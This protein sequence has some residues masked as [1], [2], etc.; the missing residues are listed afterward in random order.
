MF[1]RK[2]I[3]K[4]TIEVG[5]STLVS[6]ILGIV[7]E[8]LQVHFL[9]VGIYSDAFIAAFKI[10]NSLRKIFAEGALSSALTPTLVQIQK[11]Q[12]IDAVNKLMSLAFLIFEGILFSIVLGIY[13]FPSQVLWFV[14]PGFAPE[15]IA[16]AVPLLKILT[17]MILFISS[18]ALLAG[19]LQTSKHFLIPA[20]APVVLNIA[21]IAGLLLGI[22]RGFSVETLCFLI[23]VGSVINFCLHLLAYWH[24]HFGFALPDTQ[25]FKNLRSLL[26]KFFPFMLSMSVMEINFFIDNQFA[27]YLP[28]AVTLMHYGNR[29]MGIPLGVFAMAFSTILLPHFSRV[30]IYAPKRLTFYLYE[31]AKFILWVTL[32]ASLF[33]AYFSQDIYRTL[34]V[35]QKFPITAV[36]EA[37]SILGAF[38]IGLFAF[39]INKIL[40]NLFYALHDTQVPTWASI[41]ATSSNAVGNYILMKLYGATGLAMSTTIAG[42]IQMFFLLFFLKKRYHFIFYLK[43]FGRFVLRYAAQVFLAWT[44]FLF[45][46]T[47]IYKL[48][49]YKASPA[50]YV[51]LINKI[52]FWLWTGPLVAC[53]AC[54][55]WFTRKYFGY[56]LHFID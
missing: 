49:T 29:L 42:F 14:A 46:H 55:I 40:L 1:G 43:E 52:G 6:R 9:G 11:F 54:L 36:P 21:Y 39:S 35:S 18:S 5:A 20:I 51:F 33:L 30:G 38:V 7:R 25:A 23:V 4:K 32:P 34:F 48:I 8:I 37:A 12:S 56:K 22:Y 28:T 41:I 15:T 13:A 10:P 24:F 45:V 50:L 44:A 16:F 2:F 26:G 47:L 31:S 27:S 19:V 3:L 53:M 17:P